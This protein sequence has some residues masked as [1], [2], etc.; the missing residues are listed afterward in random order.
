MC[1]VALSFL[2]TTAEAWVPALGDVH[3]G[4]PFLSGVERLIIKD[5]ISG[6]CWWDIL[7]G[8]IR[9]AGSPGELLIPS[10]CG[11]FWESG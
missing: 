8:S 7:K 1:F 4:F 2:V 6:C 10:G 9:S 5:A 3:H 11:S